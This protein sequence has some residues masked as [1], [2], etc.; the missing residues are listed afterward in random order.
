[1]FNLRERND[2]H[3]SVGFWEYFPYC[4]PKAVKE[5]IWKSYRDPLKYENPPH[6]KE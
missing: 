5:S 4:L 1:M 3:F 2:P 6:I